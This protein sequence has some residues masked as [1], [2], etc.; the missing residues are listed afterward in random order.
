MHLIFVLQFF[1]TRT[2]GDL[3]VMSFDS[4]RVYLREE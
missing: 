1:G 3:G 4:A 2:Y